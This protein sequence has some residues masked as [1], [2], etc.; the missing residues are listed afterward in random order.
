[1]AATNRSAILDPAPLRPRR[2]DR[3]VVVDRPDINGREAIL[4]VRSQHVLLGPDV[5]LRTIAALT[6]GFVERTLPTSS[7]RLPFLPPGITKRRW[8]RLGSMRQW[9]G[10]SADWRERADS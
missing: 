2:F 8:V 3:Q 9:T 5:D 10:Q 1:M 4:N 7:I 6:P